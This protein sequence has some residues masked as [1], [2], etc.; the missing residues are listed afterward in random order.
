MPKDQVSVPH[1]V[2]L[3]DLLASDPE[4]AAE[5]LKA[6]IEDTEE[7]RAFLLAL[8]NLA[9]ALGMQRISELTGINR[10][11]LY[12]ILSQRGNPTLKTLNAILQSI[13]LKLAAVPIQQSSESHPA[14]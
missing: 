6:A 12:R 3:K 5:Y 4:F 13:G 10:E 7:P 1:S 9:E 2:V 11:S 14:A 8:R